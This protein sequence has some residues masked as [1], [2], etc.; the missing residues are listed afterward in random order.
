PDVERLQVMLDAVSELQ[1]DPGE[2]GVIVDGHRVEML[3]LLEEIKG[4]LAAAQAR[5]AVQ[6][7]ASQLAQQDARGIDRR[8]RGRGISD[9][10]A[11]ARG[12]AASRGARHL[13]FA[14]AMVEMPHTMALLSK[15]AVDEWTAT[16]LVRE[17]AILALEDRQLVDERLCAMSVDTSTGAISQPRVLDL[18]PRRV[19]AAARALACELDPEA[20]VRRAARARSDRRVTVRPAPDTMTY[21][22]ALVSVEQGVACWANLSRSARTTK[23]AGD[24]R[25]ESQIMAD[26]F[27]ERLTGQATAGAVPAEIQ[28]VMTPETLSGSSERPARL[29]DSVVPAGTARELARRRDADR[30]VRRVDTDPT[31]GA[32]VGVGRRRRLFTGTDARFLELRD[33]RCR[34]PRCDSPIADHDH[35]VPFVAGGPRS[36]A[37]G[38]GLCEAHNLVKEIPGWR[39]RVTDPRPGSHTVEVTTPTGHTYRSQAP[40]G[41]P[42]PV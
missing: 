10:V 28:L 16:L 29:G 7:E 17:T 20:A 13:G 15:G 31:T 19:E 36:R 23:A 8:M 30:S 40:P 5:L 6:F 37:N 34:H 9:Q 11:L 21:V 32:V 41:L 33:Q 22:T 42:P 24:Q 38:Q 26:L 3:R 1:G 39:S 18:T 27:V 35:V 4:A 14:K 2:T 12:S 25:T